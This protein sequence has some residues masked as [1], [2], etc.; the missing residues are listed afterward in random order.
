MAPGNRAVEAAARRSNFPAKISETE[1]GGKPG[2]FLLRESRLGGKSRGQGTGPA[3]R[4]AMVK[5]RGI[6]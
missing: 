2:L 3:S 6:S 4:N 5:A 1:A